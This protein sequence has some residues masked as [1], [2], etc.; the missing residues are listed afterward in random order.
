M[1]ET[2]KKLVSPEY[3]SRLQHW[4]RDAKPE[5][6]LGLAILDEIYSSKGN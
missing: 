1:N 5:E 2:L 6:R 3:L 4:E